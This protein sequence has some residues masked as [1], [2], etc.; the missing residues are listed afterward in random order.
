[1]LAEAWGIWVTSL[2]NQYTRITFT[3]EPDWFLCFFFFSGGNQFDTLLHHDFTTSLLKLSR[4]S[5][6][7]LN[8]N[9]QNQFFWVCKNKPLLQTI[10]FNENTDH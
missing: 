2:L 6:K 3:V 4:L 8:K 5:E 9:E 1:M 10:G 7:L